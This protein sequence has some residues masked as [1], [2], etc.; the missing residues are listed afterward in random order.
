MNQK[1]MTGYIKN[2]M[3]RNTRAKTCTTD[4]LK[5]EDNHQQFMYLS[6]FQDCESN[7]VH[8]KKTKES[9]REMCGCNQKALS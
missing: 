2:K 8:C 4:L 3:I 5:N 7:F 1:P 6:I 9:L